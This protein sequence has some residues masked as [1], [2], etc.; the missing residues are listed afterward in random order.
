MTR[1]GEQ[2]LKIIIF[3][4]FILLFVAAPGAAMRYRIVFPLIEKHHRLHQRTARGLSIPREDI[5]VLAPQTFR[6]MIRIAIP[7]DHNVAP[8]TSEVFLPP[9]EYSVLRER[10]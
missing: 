6:T 5:Y 3:R 10:H 2:R 4:H 9:L 8:F 7:A 1:K